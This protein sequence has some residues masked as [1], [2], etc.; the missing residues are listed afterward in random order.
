MAEWILDDGMA[1]PEDH[2]RH[3]CSK[4][5]WPALVYLDMNRSYKKKEFLSNYCP[6]CGVYMTNGNTKEAWS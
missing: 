1:P 3:V 2:W 6:N 4:C 5:Y